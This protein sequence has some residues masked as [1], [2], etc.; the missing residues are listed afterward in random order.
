MLIDVIVG[1]AILLFGVYLYFWVSSVALRDRIEKPKHEFLQ[2]T[3]ALS[4]D[5]GEGK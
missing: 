3:Q 2:Q 1:S 4:G 5:T